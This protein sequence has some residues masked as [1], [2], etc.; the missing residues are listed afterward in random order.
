MTNGGGGEK[1]V[2]KGV[3]GSE[4]ID[5]AWTTTKAGYY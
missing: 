2:S 5:A 3:R 4:E 1:K